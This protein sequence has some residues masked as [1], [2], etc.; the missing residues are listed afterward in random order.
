LK[1]PVLVAVV[2]LASAAVLALLAT[3]A[4]AVGDE[5]RTGTAPSPRVGADVAGRLVGARAQRPLAEALDLVRKRGGSL[6]AQL[7]RRTRALQILVPLAARGNTR[8]ANVLGVV[9]LQEASVDR[10]HARQLFAGARA[11]FVAA[12]RADPQNEDAKFN[13]ELLLAAQRRQVGRQH[14]TSAGSVGTK[15]GRA[16]GRHG[17]S[18]F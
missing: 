5:L 10:Q 14:H 17:G 11:A 3:G 18:G 8:A 13:L 7:R 9:E 6:A 15:K 12:V 2:A 4:F 16:G 1:T